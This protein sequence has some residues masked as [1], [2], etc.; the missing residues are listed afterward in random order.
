VLRR[1]C[2]VLLGTIV[3]LAAGC[4]GGDRILQPA[5]ESPP[6]S[7]DPAPEQL[8]QWIMALRATAEKSGRMPRITPIP[9]SSCPGRPKLLMRLGCYLGWCAEVFRNNCGDYLVRLTNPEGEEAWFQDG[10]PIQPDF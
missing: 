4:R 5:V 2:I 9:R 10:L 6:I 8:A 7:I 3:A 1:I